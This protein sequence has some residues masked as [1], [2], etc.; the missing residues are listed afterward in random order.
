MV[1]G[2]VW[3]EWQVYVIVS[4]KGGRDAMCAML[5]GERWRVQF[6]SFVCGSGGGLW[7]VL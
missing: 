6:V 2:L 1:Q 5:Y 7:L 3:S 4:L